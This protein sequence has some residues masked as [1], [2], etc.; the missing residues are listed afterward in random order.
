MRCGNM[1]EIKILHLFP[2]LLSLYGEY[3]N[4]ALLEKVLKDAGHS[5]TVTGWEKGELDLARYDFVYIGS[6][7]EDNLMEAI[8]R[9]APHA[10]AITASMEGGQQ[11]LAT[12][13]AMTLF[14]RTVT[15]RGTES[16]AL[17]CFGYTTELNEQKRF[18]GDAVTQPIYGAPCIGFINNSCIFRGIDKPLLELVLNPQL[19]NDKASPADGF[20]QG[21]FLGTQL[22]GPVLVK[23]PH[24]LAHVA[25]SLT[26]EALT[27]IQDSNMVKAYNISVAEL[28]N[29]I[30][31]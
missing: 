23:N 10:A 5:V 1:K 14:S 2:R 21:S 8:R 29:R 25:Q 24:F 31:A 13:N 28:Q 4:V 30:Q 22:I 3:G 7:T 26:G 15:R 19:G 9:L 18:L 12:G 20:R 6:G 16:P 27:L 11:W 17:G